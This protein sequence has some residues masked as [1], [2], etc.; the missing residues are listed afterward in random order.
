[1]WPPEVRGDLRAG[2]KAKHQGDLELSERYLRRC[3]TP[4]VVRIYAPHAEGGGEVRGR[5]RRRSLW[6]RSN[7]NPT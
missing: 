3:V 2:V 5:P 6:L 4:P 1:M 7:Q